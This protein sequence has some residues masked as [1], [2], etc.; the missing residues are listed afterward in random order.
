MSSAGVALSPRRL[1]R[2][3]TR[4]ET[5]A[6]RRTRRSHERRLLVMVLGIPL[7][8]FLG[9]GEFMWLLLVLPMVGFMVRRRR[10][11]AP[12]LFWFWL[13]TLVLVAVAAFMLENSN[14]LATY[15]L[16]SSHLLSATVVFLYVFNTSEE[17]LPARSVLL[18]LACYWGVIAVGGFLGLILGDV[19]LP[20]LAARLLPQSVV[21]NDWIKEIT[22]PG[23]A[24]TAPFM[25]TTIYRPKTFFNW[26]NE[27]GATYALLVPAAIA[28]RF[29]LARGKW[30]QILTVL[31]PASLIPF[32]FSLNRGAWMALG[33]AA[34][35]LASRF[36]HGRG[37]RLG[38]TIIISLLV[39]GALALSTPLGRVFNE[40]LETPHSNSSRMAL[41]EETWERAQDRLWLGHATPRPSV[42]PFVPR[43]GTHNLYLNF[44][45]INGLPAAFLVTSFLVSLLWVSRRLLTPVEIVV[46]VTVVIFMVEAIVY[47]LIPHPLIMLMAMG[48]LVARG[49]GSRHQLVLA[50]GSRDRLKPRMGERRRPGRRAR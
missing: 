41:Y 10:I 40:R 11:T 35:Y 16:R 9:L 19:N 8:W 7:A 38:R 39:V 24:E 45:F 12:R 28:A 21:A 22:T 6:V 47:H 30:R 34:V 13:L 20:S 2:F 26:T 44:M 43:L 4:K 48:G 46:H 5:T 31:L 32:T 25:S 36:W 14:Q 42:D 50:G 29:N 18:V 1:L 3:E 37:A 33:V 49:I 17:E 15:L 23:F 27:W